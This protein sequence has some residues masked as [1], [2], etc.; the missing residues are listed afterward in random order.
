VRSA[1]LAPEGEKVVVDT[2]WRTEAILFAKSIPSSFS[3][4]RKGNL[5]RWEDKP[6]AL[7][8]QKEKRQVSIPTARPET[9]TALA[10]SGFLLELCMIAKL[11]IIDCTDLKIKNPWNTV[12]SL[13]DSL[14]GAIMA[15]RNEKLGPVDNVPKPVRRGF[16]YVLWYAFAERT[17]ETEDNAFVSITRTTTLVPMGAAWGDLTKFPDLQ[18]I[19]AIVRAAAQTRAGAIEGPKKFLK[20]EGYFLDKLVGKKPVMGL[21]TDEEF[22]RVVAYWSDKQ[23]YIQGT[24]KAL[25]DD[26]GK[27]VGDRK[28]AGVMALFSMKTPSLIKDIED[29]KSKRIPNLLVFTGRGKNRTSEIAKGSTLQDKIISLGG[30]DNPRLPARILWSPLDGS[31][32]NILADFS[33]KFARSLLLRNNSY[34]QYLQGLAKIDESSLKLATV[35]ESKIKQVANVVVECYPDHKGEPVWDSIVS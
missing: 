35:L 9:P 21:Y 24:Y 26:W 33:L 23:K 20:G 27:I 30:G 5:E 29:A 22:A 14:V 6:F 2:N 32:I 15:C 31:S 34:E 11:E 7:N 1:I 4:A 19:S 10:A 28:V 17:K 13:G 25:P 3:E 18:K 12:E 8:I 16:E